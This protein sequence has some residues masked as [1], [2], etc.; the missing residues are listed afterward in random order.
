MSTF[1]DA[2]RVRAAEGWA[3][4][5]LFGVVGGRCECSKRGEC[6]TPGKHP[7]LTNY[8]EKATRDPRRIKLLWGQFPLAN[9]GG[10]PGI[11]SGINVLD[12]D[13]RNGGE[14]SLD[15]LTHRY[16]ALPE[17]VEALT[18]AG[19][20]HLYFRH[21]GHDLGN[22][23][24]ILGPGLDIRSTGGNVVLPGSIHASGRVYEY[25]LAHSPE[26]APLAPMPGWLLGLLRAA[27]NGHRKSAPPMPPGPILEGVRHSTL[28]SWAGSMHARGMS[29][30]AIVA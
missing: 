2:A 19:G 14:D 23:A 15:L 4:H 8:Y 29:P 16:G 22:T 25:E 20:R 24:G 10:A 13:P 7:R 18:G 9:V 6:P 12:I 30:G 21:E 26:D 3:V 5:P 1:L 11:K 28:V 17:T 27:G